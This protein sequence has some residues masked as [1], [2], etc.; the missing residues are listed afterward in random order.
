MQ[1]KATLCRLALLLSLAGVAA[2]QA[3]KSA[4]PTIPIEGLDP[5]LLVQGKEVQGNEKIFSV[6]GHYKYI[7]SSQETK[8]AFE[9]NPEP[10]EVGEYCQ[11]MGAPVTGNP[12]LHAEHKGKIYIFGSDDCIKAF[13]A[14]PDDFIEPVRPAWSPSSAE[15]ARGQALLDKAVAAM[16]G[17]AA[18]EQLSS[19][20]E[21][22][23]QK[24]KMR[25]GSE[26]DN[27]TEVFRAFP[28]GLRQV[29]VRRFGTITTAFSATDG[30]S[31]FESEGRSNSR[32]MGADARERLEIEL[33]RNPV[34]LLR[35]RARADF[36][37]AAVGSGTA[38]DVAVEFVNLETRG[39]RFTLGI[40]PASGR[41]VSL[42]LV[43]RGLGGKFG[44]GQLLFADYRPAGSLQLPNRVEATFNGQPWPDFTYTV[45]Q[46]EVNKPISA[47]LFEKPKP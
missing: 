39:Q 40:E 5:V 36:R 44:T 38:G 47:A 7:F 25:D 33:L 6:R 46:L 14:A 9:K 23:L 8:A 16:G 19:F 10:C 22:R 34:F 29:Q 41:V 21:R 42:S 18:L 12:D 2:S 45:T 15:T 26:F 30:Y 35:S 3:P 20:W 17:A 43:S 13:K 27:I 24:I 32:P 37:V 11:R 1:T 4:E 28:E 31:Q